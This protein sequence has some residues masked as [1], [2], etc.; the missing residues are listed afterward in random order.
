MRGR[1]WE[2]RA[3][4]KYRLC[5]PGQFYLT[6]KSIFKAPNIIKKCSRFNLRRRDNLSLIDYVGCPSPIFV[7]LGWRCFYDIHV[8]EYVFGCLTL[9]R[10]R[11]YTGKLVALRGQN[12]IYTHTYIYILFN[13]WSA[14]K[15]RAV[16]I[17]SEFGDGD[18]CGH[19]DN[20]WGPQRRAGGRRVHSQRG[21]WN[22]RHRHWLCHDWNPC[23]A[24]PAHGLSGGEEV[25]GLD[26]WG[27]FPPWLSGRASK[28]L[29][30]SYCFNK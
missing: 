5:K 9:K 24:P 2:T 19:C 25:R 4:Y 12:M 18:T 14:A 16:R 8:N 20:E 10:L 15:P 3:T 11:E 27:P 26:P 13:Q 22:L 7:F 28:M 21:D 30:K 6:L 17:E 29:G 23:P 1:N